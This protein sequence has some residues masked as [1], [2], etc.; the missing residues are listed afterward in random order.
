MSGRVVRR[1][2]FV[3][4]GECY[5]NRA[6]LIA[7]PD[8]ELTW[9]GEK[10]GQRLGEHFDGCGGINLSR[11]LVRR[12]ASTSFYIASRT[13]Y[14]SH[15]LPG[16]AEVD[17]GKFSGRPVDEFDLSQW[18]DHGYAGVETPEDV[19]ERSIP[20]IRDAF[21]AGDSILVTHAA[22][23]GLSVC[24]LLGWDLRCFQRMSIPLGSITTLEFDGAV[25]RLTGLGLQ[26]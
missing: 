25:W 12:V 6:G 22:V 1:L 10:Q 18:Y 3:R 4:H 14:T 23:I 13:D 21:E 15:R 17:F 16:L 19:T 7:R 5:D 26:P 9:E 11:S 24:Y 8:S 20:A 2:Y